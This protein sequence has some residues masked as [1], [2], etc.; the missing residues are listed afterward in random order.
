MAVVKMTQNGMEG[1]SGWV[2][3]ARVLY[4]QH[5][6]MKTVTAAKMLAYV[7]EGAEKSMDMSARMRNV[8]SKNGCVTHFPTTQKIQHAAETGIDSFAIIIHF[9][10]ITTL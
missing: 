9:T 10:K 1:I 2:V 6:M 8:A 3:L 4:A 5:A 7:M